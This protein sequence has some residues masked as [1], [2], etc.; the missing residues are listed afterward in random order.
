MS[1][2]PTQILRLRFAPRRMTWSHSTSPHVIGRATPAPPQSVGVMCVRFDI[3][4]TFWGDL[5]RFYYAN[6]ESGAIDQTRTVGKADPTLWIGPARDGR[7][8]EVMTYVE[9]S[10]DLVVFHC[11]ELCDKFRRQMEGDQS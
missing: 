10:R 3:L 9:P 11:M 1:C 6:V 5:G 8:I 2:V 7:L 4:V